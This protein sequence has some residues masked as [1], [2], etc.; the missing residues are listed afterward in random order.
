MADA[1]VVDDD[2]VATSRES[3]DNIEQNKISNAM[4]LSLLLLVSSAADDDLRRR[5]TNGFDQKPLW[6]KAVTKT[7][8]TP[9]GDWMTILA[10]IVYRREWR[11]R[12]CCRLEDISTN[13]AWNGT[14]T[15]PWRRGGF[16]S[17]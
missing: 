2:D 6:T 3:K 8:A 14:S 10:L 4:L 15:V 13:E 12:Q 11:R 1:V 7:K 16:D 17:R 9:P 5:A